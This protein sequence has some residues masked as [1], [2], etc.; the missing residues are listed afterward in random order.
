MYTRKS[1]V[2]LLLL[3]QKTLKQHLTAGSDGNTGNVHFFNHILGRIWSF[4]LHL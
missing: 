3:L 2:M 1:T 4:D